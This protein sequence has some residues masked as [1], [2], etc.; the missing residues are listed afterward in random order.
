MLVSCFQRSLSPWLATVLASVF[1]LTSLLAQAQSGVDES[2]NARAS[3]GRQ[4]L[5]TASDETPLRKRARIRLELATA[6]FSKGDLRTALDEVKQVLSIDSNFSEALELRGLVYDALQEPALAEESFNRA[7]Q[8][9]PRNGSAMHNFGWFLCRKKDYEQ[10][11]A[12]F[13]R[14]QQQGFSVPTAK[15]LL[16][17]GVCQI[18]AGKV[19]LAEK[20]IARSYE[21]DPS[22]AV[23]AYNLARVLMLQ[24]EAQRA[25]FY[26]RRVNNVPEQANA[27]SLWLGIRIENKLGNVSE[28]DELASALRSRF[29]S[30][31]EAT[32]LELGRFDE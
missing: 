4:D 6:Y 31:R 1:A 10:A 30:S 18:E 11:D 12:M 21:L 3:G 16:V 28:R 5:T 26:I 27:E 17:R 23:T 13:G 7:L 32:A 29:G 22:S 15:T 2:V 20:T 25:R 9:N 8:A 19:A 24:G 14:A